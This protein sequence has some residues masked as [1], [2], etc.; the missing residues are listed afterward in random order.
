MCKNG[1]LYGFLLVDMHTRDSL[2][3]HFADFP[4][5]M[6]NTM[7]GKKNIGSEMAAFAEKHGFLKTSRK[8]LI[9]SYF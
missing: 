4:P 6:K 2:K 7:V 5:F 3:A 1:S 9:S 8:M